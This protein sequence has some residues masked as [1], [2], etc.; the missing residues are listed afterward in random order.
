MVLAAFTATG[1]LVAGTHAWYLLKDPAHVFH[2]RACTIA[3]WVSVIPALLQPVRGDLLAQQVAT[4]QPAK[5]AR[6]RSPFSHAGR[7]S[8]LPGGLPDSETQTVPYSLAIPNGLSLLVHHDPNAVVIGL[9]QF[10][11]DQW[12]PVSIVHAAFQLMVGSGFLL[13]G[14]AVWSVWRWWRHPGP[15]RSRAFLWALVAVSPLGFLAIEA[16]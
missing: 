14:V 1:F 9:D 4:Y 2:Q 3:L 8:L 6:L 15:F 5:L 13:M 7:V 16:G 10:P 12:P 11:Q